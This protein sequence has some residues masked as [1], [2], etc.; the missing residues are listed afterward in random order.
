VD[1]FRAHLAYVDKSE[2]I[3]KLLDTYPQWHINF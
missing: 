2:V 3:H 1:K